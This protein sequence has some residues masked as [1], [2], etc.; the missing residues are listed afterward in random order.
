MKIPEKP[1]LNSYEAAL[2]DEQ[3]AAFRALLLSYRVS[4][5]TLS[6]AFQSLENPSSF[7]AVSLIGSERRRWSCTPGRLEWAVAL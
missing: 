3:R 7:C 5:I 4:V 2:T 1:H 6:D